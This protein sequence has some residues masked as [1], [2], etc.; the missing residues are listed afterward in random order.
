MIQSTGSKQTRHHSVSHAETHGNHTSQASRKPVRA[1][2]NLRPS[3]HGRKFASLS[4][5]G[6][7]LSTQLADLEVLRLLFMVIQ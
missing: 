4:Q 5:E 3:Q 6:V 2:S 7:Y 1:G